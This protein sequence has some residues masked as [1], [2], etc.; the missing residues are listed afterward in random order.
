MNTYW[1]KLFV[2]VAAC[3]GVRAMNMEAHSH[4]TSTLSAPLDLSTVVPVAHEVHHMHGVPILETELTPAERLFWEAYNTTSYFTVETPYKSQLYVHLGLVYAAFVLVYPIVL[5]LRNVNSKWF[6][7][8]LTV[9]SVMVIASLFSY[10]LFISNA[11]DLYPNNAYSKM[12]TGL[13]F[14]VIVHLFSS[15]VYTAKKWLEG[16]SPAT[17]APLPG[18]D[19]QMSELNGF[20]SPSSTLY[21]SDDRLHRLS[22]DSLDLEDQGSSTPTSHHSGAASPQKPEFWLSRLFQLAPVAKLVSIFGLA[23]TFNF[24]VLNYGMLCYFLIYAPTGIAVLS[25]IGMGNHVFNLLAHFIKGGVFFT[26]GIISLTRYCGGWSKLGWAWNRSY[27][28]PFEKPTSFWYKLQPKNGMITMEM[29]ESSLIL[30]YGSTNVFLEHLAAPGGP[31]TAKDL[32]HVSIAFLYIGAGLCGVVSEL[33]LADWRLD[34]F[35]S[36]VGPDFEVQGYRPAHVTPGFSPNPFPAFTIF[37]TGLL[38]SQ[39]QQASELS[40]SVHVQWG[41]LLT[42]GSVVRLV[43]FLLMIFFPKS[44]SFQPTKPF[45]ELLT[46]FCLLCGGLVFMESTDPVI[47]ALEYRGLTPMFTMNVSVGVISLLMAWIM[48]VFSIRDRLK[49][50][51][52]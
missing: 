8:S 2:A 7:P 27:I 31:W 30:F 14:L 47:M 21:D 15:F 26:L 36:Q 29:V 11:P 51:S 1:I 22:A 33:K 24:H 40:T 34:K 19:I 49:A 50:G 39:H 9:H 20:S 13:F 25:C 44:Q 3:H 12:S 17:H 52:H 37:W 28:L 5:V 46:S 43:T 18:K 16:P 35:Y 48:C 32:Q 4:A 41:S 6:L 23:S 38:M 45:T 10:S 42:Y